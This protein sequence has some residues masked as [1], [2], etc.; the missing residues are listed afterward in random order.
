MGSL[1]I[2]DIQIVNR[3]V[4]LIAGENG[5]LKH[6]MMDSPGKQLGETLVSLAYFSLINQRGGLLEIIIRTRRSA[7]AN[8]NTFFIQPMVEKHGRNY[9]QQMQMILIAIVKL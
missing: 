8:S 7:Y 5:L 3:K 1:F 4:G 6:M 9:P 2:N